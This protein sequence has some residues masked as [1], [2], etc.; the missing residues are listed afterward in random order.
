[1]VLEAAGFIAV[2]T[3]PQLQD[4]KLRHPLRC[5]SSRHQEVFDLLDG[6]SGA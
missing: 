3:V 5:K 1:M 6:A 4:L 2:G